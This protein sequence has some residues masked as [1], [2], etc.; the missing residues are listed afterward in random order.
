MSHVTCEEI[1]KDFL[2]LY[3]LSHGD[4]HFAKTTKLRASCTGLNDFFRKKLK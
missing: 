1:N 4:E 3:N 2:E